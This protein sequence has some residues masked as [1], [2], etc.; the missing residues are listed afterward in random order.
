M[1]IFRCYFLLLIFFSIFC[2]SQKLIAQ[3]AILYGVVL[4]SLSQEPLIGAT[5]QIEGKEGK[6]TDIEGKFQFSLLPGNY[7][8]EVRYIGY[9]TLLLQNIFLE[10]GKTQ[11]LSILMRP[12]SI[13]LE[14][15]VVIANIE[16]FTVSALLTM[17]KNSPNIEDGISLETI[18]KT[19]DRNVSQ[20]I[21]R[22]SGV[23]IQEGRFAI[24]RGLADRYNNALLNNLLLPSSEADRKVFAFDIFPTALLDNLVVLKTATPNLPG[25]FAGGIIQIQTRSVPDTPFLEFSLGTSFNTITTFQK[26][27][28]YIGGKWDFIGLDDGIRALPPSI[29]TTAELIKAERSQR[30]EWA[31]QIP[32]HWKMIEGNFT[33]PG[34]SFQL[35]AGKRYALDRGRKYSLGLLG[36]FTYSLQYNLRPTQRA[37]FDTDGKINNYNDVQFFQNT[38]TGGL[39]NLTLDLTAQHRITWQNLFTI[40]GQDQTIARSGAVVKG[41]GSLRKSNAFIFQSTPMY[42]MQ[43]SSEHAPKLIPFKFHW[44]AGITHI[45]VNIPNYRNLLYVKAPDAPD[46]IPYR[47]EVSTNVDLDQGGMFY[48]HAQEVQYSVSCALHYP[49]IMANLPQNI[50]LGIGYQNKQRSFSARILG[51]VIARTSTFDYNLLFL[52]PSSIFATE[53]FSDKGFAL[54]ENTNLQDKYD[55]SGKLQ[56]YYF[57][58]TNAIT[59]KLKAIW[60]LRLEIFR[61]KLNSFDKTDAPVIID[62]TYYDYLPSLSFIYSASSKAN[63]RLGVSQTVSRPEF[64]ELAPFA[65]YDFTT[66]FVVLGNPALYRTRIWNFDVRF[67]YYPTVSE[68]FSFS[69]FYKRFENPIEQVIQ[70]GTGAGSTNITFSNIKAGADNRGIEVEARKNFGFLASWLGWKKA[71]YLVTSFNCALIYSTIDVAEVPG[72]IPGV[73]PLQ[74]QSAYIFNASLQYTFPNVGLSLATFLNQ[75]G[76]RI[77]QVGTQEYPH[78]WENPRLLWD[79]QIGKKIHKHWEVKLTCS[80]LLAQDLLFYQDMDNFQSIREPYHNRHGNGRFNEEK[81]NVIQRL[82]FGQVLSF[83]IHAKW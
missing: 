48:S 8:I 29:P 12:Q 27:N 76:R 31:K 45:A 83:S 50:Q 37:D 14:E 36:A 17:Q 74:G 4:D 15:V 28:S 26:H 43:L 64:R 69:L 21:K 68:I 61:Q 20:A 19:P 32:N 35:T 42:S 13:G 59:S 79:F 39:L 70:F 30:I 34:L 80:D 62:T 38:L 11:Q 81:D 66:N 33:Y 54:R 40:R 52:P 7:T 77:A 53:N 72:T 10:S 23:S 65:F 47:A 6:V 78:V 49:F 5:V 63:F 57:M 25:E 51:F 71:E 41:T 44:E 67:E 1:K 2:W 46:T 3:N 22:V 73:R 56:S 75:V 16:K 55:A 18:S 24:I 58:N 82:R 60:G 9:Q